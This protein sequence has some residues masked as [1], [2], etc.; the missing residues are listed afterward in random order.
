MIKPKIRES[1]HDVLTM[2][3]QDLGIISDLFNEV[4][5]RDVPISAENVCML[6]HQF[7]ENG[8][9]TKEA[10]DKL[11]AHAYRH[12][13]EFQLRSLFGGLRVAIIYRKY[14]LMEFF[15]EEYSAHKQKF[16]VLE[17]LELAEAI[18]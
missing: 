17:L 12:K 8:L 9:M 1:F 18:N 11:E 6:L 16:T 5:R 15:W 10:F 3:S 13:G 14:K 2:P 4:I 7:M